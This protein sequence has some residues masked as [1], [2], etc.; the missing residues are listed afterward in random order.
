C[1]KSEISA[2]NEKPCPPVVVQHLPDGH[3]ITN[4]GNGK[5]Q[6]KT[7]DEKVYTCQHDSNYDGVHI[8]HTHDKR[9]KLITRPDYSWR[10]W[11]ECQEDD[12]ITGLVRE[13]INLVKELK[14]SGAQIKD[15]VIA[16]PDGTKITTLPHKIVIQ[17]REGRIVETDYEGNLMSL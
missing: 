9:N 16:L 12:K 3:T 13:H 17:N 5:Y 10:S 14:N 1:K 4:I 2:T 6:V 8:E 15:N 7:P 11:E